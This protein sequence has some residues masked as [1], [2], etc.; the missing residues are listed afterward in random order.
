MSLLKTVQQF[1]K[2]HLR[3]DKP[4]LLGLSGGSDSICLL[5]LIIEYRKEFPLQL[6]IAHIDHGWRE[7]SKMEAEALF[8]LCT[9]LKLPFHKL[10]LNPSELKGNLE[11]ACRYK[12]LT[13]YKKLRD[14][15]DCQATLLAHHKNDQEETVL[16]RIFEGYSLTSLHGMQEVSALDGLTIWRPLLSI[17]KEEILTFLQKRDI[18]WFEDR[19][20]RDPKYLRAKLRED[21]IPTLEKSFGKK[22]GE[23]LLR[24]AKE[25]HTLKAF[26]EESLGFHL[27]EIKSGPFGH[28]IDLKPFHE[29]P[30]VLEFLIKKFF[31]WGGVYISHSLRDALIKH[32]SLGSANRRFFASHQNI[33]VDRFK[34]FLIKDEILMEPIEHIPLR[35]GNFD[36][37]VWHVSVKKANFCKTSSWQDLWEGVGTVLLPSEDY[38]L[39]RATLNA[40][41]L[42]TTLNKWWTDHKVP[43]FLRS[44]APVIWNNNWIAHEFLT[45]RRSAGIEEGSG[46]EVKIQLKSKHRY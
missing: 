27:K 3:E 24:L 9:N 32:L 44:M 41:V 5:H 7:E 19:T 26:L 12:R 17:S 6:H 28:F 1:L 46:F 38:I 16:K 33:Y 43:A 22:M 14:Q 15:F 8:Q 23:P 35:S 20:N 36:V 37:G 31:E 40:K 13:F 45:G 29:K 21:L 42:H 25:S 39:G 4:I 2:K 34:L 18:S 10:V 11:E 30:F